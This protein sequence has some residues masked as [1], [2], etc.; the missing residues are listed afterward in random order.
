MGSGGG[1]VLLL[2]V[3]E[4]EKGVQESCGEKVKRG[5]AVVVR[6]V[7]GRS[8]TSSLSNVAYKP[9]AYSIVT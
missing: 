9:L 7:G 1:V 6:G 4:A 8:V 2:R 5:K 3:Q